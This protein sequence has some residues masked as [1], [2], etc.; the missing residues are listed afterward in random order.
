MLE[1]CNLPRPLF[2]SLEVLP[3]R[4]EVVDT[5][6]QRTVFLNGY[7]AARYCCDDKVAER[8]LL[9]Q[10]AEVLPLPDLQI[11]AAFQIHPVTLSRFRATA[12][13]GGT[14]AL[15]PSKSRLGPN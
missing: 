10:L 4:L 13:T 7:V 6:D 8:V 2:D 12:R 1:L 5:G 11:A 15:V 9:T 3:Q 14:A